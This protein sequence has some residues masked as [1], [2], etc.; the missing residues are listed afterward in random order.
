MYY[1]GDIGVIDEKIINQNI[2]E[3]VIRNR[4]KGINIVKD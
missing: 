4:F 3:K 1:V 2:F